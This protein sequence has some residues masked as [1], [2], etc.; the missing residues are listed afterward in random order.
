MLD[1]VW[2]QQL[3]SVGGAILHTGDDRSGGGGAD[4]PNDEV[5]VD[6]GILNLAV[7]TLISSIN[8]FTGESFDGIPNVFCAQSNVEIGV[9]VAG[10]S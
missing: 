6:L 2:F 4:V 9:E 7:K 3:R 5:R 8:S 1:Q 10:Q